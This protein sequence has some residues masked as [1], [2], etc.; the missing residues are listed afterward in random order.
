MMMP[1]PICT[2]RRVDEEIFANS[3]LAPR[4]RPKRRQHG[5]HWRIVGMAQEE[6]VNEQ[7]HTEREEGEAEAHPRPTEGVA[8]RCVVDQ[9]LVGPTDPWTPRHGG[10]GGEDQ[11]IRRLTSCGVRLKASVHPA[12][13]FAICS[14]LASSSRTVTTASAKGPGSTTSCFVRS[15][16]WSAPRMV[17]V[18]AACWSGWS[19]TNALPKVPIAILFCVAVPRR[20]RVDAV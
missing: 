1:A 7:D 9:R 10:K 16:P 18:T 3:S 17:A 14:A 11:K 20:I 2:S 12:A 13:G 6:L 4:Q 5:V 8:G 15:T 19:A